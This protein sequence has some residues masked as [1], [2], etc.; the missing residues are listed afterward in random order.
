MSIKDLLATNANVCVSISVADLNEFLLQVINDK[1]E[2]KAQEEA[3]ETYLTR[4]EASKM[5][6]GAAYSTLWRWEK[7]GY[8]VPT[9]MGSKIRYRKS[10]VV[11]LLKEG[12]A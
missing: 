5:L 12:V 6:G 11:K 3:E 10:D 4:E 1:M 8:L 7:T 9:R 2:A